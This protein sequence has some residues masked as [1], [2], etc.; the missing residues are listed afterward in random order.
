MPTPPLVS[1]E[2]VVSASALPLRVDFTSS[3]FSAIHLF[4]SCFFL[5]LMLPVFHAHVLG[6]HSDLPVHPKECV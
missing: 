5:F 2:A 3:R 6:H 1:P 4:H